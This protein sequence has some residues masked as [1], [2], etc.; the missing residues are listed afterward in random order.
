MLIQFGRDSAKI[1]GHSTV[2][3]AIIRCG[4]EAGPQNIKEAP[5]TYCV[6]LN[7]IV[8]LVHRQCF[9]WEKVWEILFV[10]YYI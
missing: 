2:V 9:Q 5:R 10:S 4:D 8:V 3:D 7:H 1:K 6:V